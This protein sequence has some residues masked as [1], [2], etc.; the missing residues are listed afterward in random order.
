ME[1]T[2]AACLNHHRQF[3]YNLIL[4]NITYYL[5]KLKFCLHFGIKSIFCP[6]LRFPGALKRPFL[7]ILQH[8]LKLAGKH[9]ECLAGHDFHGQGCHWQHE[10]DRGA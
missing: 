8:W 6:M 10:G 9:P 5:N 2:G 3:F 4:V 7:E 1:D